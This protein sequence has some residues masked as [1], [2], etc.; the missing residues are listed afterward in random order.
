M[1][2]MLGLKVRD[3]TIKATAI[4]AMVVVTVRA[5]GRLVVE[6]ML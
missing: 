1:Y 4:R 6:P 3:M 2:R 5:M